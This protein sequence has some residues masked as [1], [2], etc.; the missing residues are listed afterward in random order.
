MLTRLNL[1][2]LEESFDRYLT[3]W[4]TEPETFD[5]LDVA[6]NPIALELAWR[7]YLLWHEEDK[8]RRTDVD[9][10][11]IA[12]VKRAIDRLNQQR[13]DLIEKLDEAILEELSKTVPESPTEVINSE[14]PGSIVDRISIMSL[15]VYHMDE[16]SRRE[17]IDEQHRQRSLHRLGVLRL[18]RHDLYEALGYLLE[19]YRA[20]RKRMKL[21]KQ[22]KMYNDP[23][24]NPE[25]YRTRDQE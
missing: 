7:N 19:D 12:A 25:L 10:S 3:F 23:A 8:A 11:A 15:K 2:K 24:L 17:D 22:F 16:D 18:Q 14:T 21:Y 20:G 1:T 9:D 4:H 6:V 13:N 5:G